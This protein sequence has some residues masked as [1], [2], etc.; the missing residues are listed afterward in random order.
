MSKKSFHAE[1]WIVKNLAPSDQVTQSTPKKFLGQEHQLPEFCPLQKTKMNLNTNQS[2]SPS[3]F[4]TRGWQGRTLSTPKS[5]RF[6][7]L[8]QI[9]EE[10]A[11]QSLLST[12]N[13]FNNKIKAAIYEEF[14]LHIESHN[15]CI[16]GYD[17]SPELFW[18]QLEYI[19]QPQFLELNNFFKRYCSNVVLIY[20]FKVRFML[21]LGGKTSIVIKESHLKNPNNLLNKVFCK[22]SLTEIPSISL[23]TNHYSW[24]RPSNEVV[25]LISENKSD[26]QA[27]GVDEL[28]KTQQETKSQDFSHSLSHLNFGLLVNCLLINLPRWLSNQSIVDYQYH[29]NFEN[30][31]ILATQFTGDYLESISTSHWLAQEYNTYQPWDC[32][33]GPEFQ[34]NDHYS[35]PFFKIISELQFL[36]FLCQLSQIHKKNPIQYIAQ[37]FQ[38]A[39]QKKHREENL[40]SLFFNGVQLNRPLFDRVVLTLAH[41]PSSNSHYY[42][43]NQVLHHLDSIRI[44]GFLYVMSD[45]KLLLPGQSTRVK[46]LLRHSPLLAC[47]DFSE[48]KGKGEIPKY[49]YIFSRSKKHSIQRH[50]QEIQSFFHLKFTGSLGSFYQFEQIISGVQDFL[51]E[52]KSNSIPLYFK[53]ISEHIGLTVF[54][55]HIINGGLVEMEE[56]EGQTYH[57]NFVKNLVQNCTRFD[58]FY[59]ITPIK[60]SYRQARSYSS[61]HQLIEFGEDSQ[62][63]YF[64]SYQLEKDCAQIKIFPIQNLESYVDEMGFKGI[65]YF[66][67][68]SKHHSVSI[69]NFQ[70]LFSSRIGKQLINISSSSFQTILQIIKS[71]LIPKN[72]LCLSQHS[73]MT[74][75]SEFDELEIQEI[76]HHYP[77]IREKIMTVAHENYS[78][79]I[80]FLTKLR[81]NLDVLNDPSLNQTQYIFRQEIVLNNLAKLTKYPLLGHDDLYIEVF[82]SEISGHVLEEIVYQPSQQLSSLV[83]KDSSG[84]SLG[85]LRGPDLLIQFTQFLL[86]MSKGHRLKT[87]LAGIKLPRYSDLATQ[88][89]MSRKQMQQKNSCIGLINED[90]EILLRKSIFT[91]NS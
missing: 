67:L 12:Y 50:S 6:F 5:L 23:Q 62:F 27:M 29:L 38:G 65:Y 24:F 33:I 1:N 71:L 36:N 8:C 53:Q 47:I 86:E 21:S 59:R 4:L 40:Q 25:K 58:F 61:S 43:T 57:P 83:L 35:C 52:S 81:K 60:P 2:F 45:Q 48:L 78:L 42:L 75:P 70:A 84:E 9:L 72:F 55:R 68:N 54:Q 66:G 10:H 90:I 91:Q 85:V 22:G 87:I 44:D 79:Y 17:Q 13:R 89:E 7:N 15:L 46:K 73:E 3:Q 56:I 77:R 41:L 69:E 32:I 64:L 31:D 16:Q 19:D 11:Y 30:P 14:L 34:N 49:L 80:S 76:V 82:A 63:D 18:E 39:H 51:K 74:L 37:V 20:L 88:V 28:L 26:I